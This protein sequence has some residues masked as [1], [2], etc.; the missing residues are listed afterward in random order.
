MFVHWLKSLFGRRSTPVPPILMRVAE[1]DGGAPPLLD[2]QT[3]WLPSGRTRER[4]LRTA[5][6]LCV[7][8]WLP[9]DDVVEI[10]V[11]S[12]RGMAVVEH[13][14][15]DSGGPVIPVQLL[16]SESVAASTKGRDP[17]S[18]VC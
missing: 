12:T 15:S 6:G 13:H 7:L 16:T 3:R 9:E 11:R 18:N 2:V 17:V 10:T 4:S 1:P 5:D 8:H 14:V